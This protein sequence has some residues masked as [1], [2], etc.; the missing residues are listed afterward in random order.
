[1][2]SESQTPQEAGN[3]EKWIAKA[4][5]GCPEALG[6]LLDAC[7]R[8]LLLVA[9]QELSPKFRA[10][11]DPSDIVQDTLMKAGRAFPN[12]LGAT[13]E[14][15]LGWLRRILL[16]IVA[17]VHRHFKT[18]K[19][20]VGREVPLETATDA[21]LHGAY[22][23]TE[24]PSVHAQVREQD[25][26]LQRALREL[27]GHYR[28]VLQLHSSEGLTFV[29]IAEKLESTP[30]AIRKL[31]GRAVEELAKLLDSPHESSR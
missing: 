17:N 9:N 16:N 18:G 8:Y 11:V 31:W 30:D 27:P 21:L 5:E 15:L 23:D 14:E 26:Q 25:E 1:M 13:E 6:R 29:Q 20:G 4:R 2:S 24:T 22:E 19:R 3:V 10:K 28:Q 12:F 7:R